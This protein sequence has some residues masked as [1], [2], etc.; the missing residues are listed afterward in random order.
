MIE[1]GEGHLVIE[2]NIDDERNLDATLDLAQDRRVLRLRHRDAHEFAARFL[3]AMDFG[4]YGV[5]VRSVGRGHRLDDDRMIA[6]DGHI[7]DRD[8]ARF[9][10]V[11]DVLVH[12]SRSCIRLAFA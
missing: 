11:E 9:V 2:V 1:S 12:R 4:E 3:E 8:D 5:N 10:A 6:A 7:A